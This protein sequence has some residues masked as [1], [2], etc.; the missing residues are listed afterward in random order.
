MYDAYF[1]IIRIVRSVLCCSIRIQGI[2]RRVLCCIIGIAII[3]TVLCCIIDNN[4][5]VM[6]P[7]CHNKNNKESIMLQHLIGRQKLVGGSTCPSYIL[8]FF[9]KKY[10]NWLLRPISFNRHLAFFIGLMEPNYFMYVH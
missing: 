3:M 6:L 10:L 2:R 1:G 7:N 9:H 4:E 8:L 5:S